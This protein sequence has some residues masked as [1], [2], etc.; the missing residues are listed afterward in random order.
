MSTG[1]LNGVVR[2]VRRAAA[3]QE[4]TDRTDAEFL[5]AF[6]ER[7]DGFAFEALV[8]R[9][10]PMVLGVC[11]RIIGHRQ[12]A[13]DAF[14]AAFL[15][16]ARKAATVSPRNLLGNWLYG[17]AH[18][19]AVRARALGVRRQ[20]RERQVTAMPES[21][22]TSEKAWD[23]VRPVLD[24][25]VSRLPDRYRAVLVLCDVQGRTRKDAARHLGCPEGSVSSRLA[26]AREMLAKRLSR[27]GIALSG[28]ALAALVSEHAAASLPPA[29]VGSTISAAGLFA[30]ASVPPAVQALAGGVMKTMAL[31]TTTTTAGWILLAAAATA[32]LGVAAHHLQ[33]GQGAGQVSGSLTVS[34]TKEGRSVAEKLVQE[35]GNDN[36]QEREAAEKALRAMG[37]K[38]YPAVRAGMKSSVPE[39][40]QRC[41]RIAPE[42]RVAAIKE[43]Y[44]PLV[45]RYQKVVGKTDADRKLYREAVSDVRR[46]EFL[47]AAELRPDLAGELYQKELDRAISALAKGYADAE[48]A[49]GGRTGVLVATSGVPTEGEMAALLFLGTFPSTAKIVPTV[50]HS[51]LDGLYHNLI[52]L[53]RA[54][55][56][57]PEIPAPERRLFAAW[58]A[59]R[60]DSLS[61]RIG[62]E[63]AAYHDI[64]E[65]RPVACRIAA[66]K[67]LSDAERARALFVVGQSGDKADAA[68]CEPLFKSEA[69]YWET[70]YTDG[71]NKQVPVV[72]Q[73]RDIAVAV[74]LI[75]HGQEPADYEFDMIA[76][77][78]ARGPEVLKKYHLFG[79][80]TDAGRKAA[81]EKAMAF[82]SKTKR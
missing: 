68:L 18:Q 2:H 21:T 71:K 37:G 35:L 13:E 61:V 50:K 80:R 78:N 72:T 39:I 40:A 12:D 36:F 11:R 16:L 56:S 19:T 44:H 42:L 15:V 73:V 58:L 7:R 8:R 14:Q 22:A 51:W 52:G 64:P 53:R 31:K 26:R 59:N 67:T 60:G 46:A 4:E 54:G 10:G 70:K 63:Y 75:L 25:E 76:L 34:V 5:T 47:E 81:H 45:V 17:V 33:A 3:R 69:V 43:S 6:I 38:A 9:H 79:F 82:L 41:E 57:P 23:D 49:A 55:E 28:G 62:L 20:R 29:L 65:A 74:A 24:E 32:G 66:D 77:Y 30:A 1:G 48:Q 27:R